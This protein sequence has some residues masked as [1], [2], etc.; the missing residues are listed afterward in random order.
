MKIIFIS[1]RLDK[2]GKHKELRDNIDTRFSFFLEK[3]G[4]TPI[5]IPNNSNQLRLIFKKIKPNGI[6]LSPGG[7]P[8]IKDER[9]KVENMLIN[10]SKKNSIPL[11]GICRGA[12]VIN[13]FFGGKIKKINNHVRKNHYIFGKIINNKV[14]LKSKCFHEY[15]I[16][17]NILGKNLKVLAFS[18]DGSIE[19]FKHYKKKIMGIMWHPERFKKFRKFEINLIKNFF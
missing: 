11:L 15:G 19:C 2:F 3:T 1:Q 10:Y 13:L 6:I 16:K 12:Q 14:Q 17:E 8:K 18:K 4:L 9:H 5:L 7:N